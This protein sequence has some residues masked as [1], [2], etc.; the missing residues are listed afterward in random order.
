M[1]CVI[2]RNEIYY[3][4]KMTYKKYLF[5]IGAVAIIGWVSFVL[6][7]LKLDPCTSPG[8]LSLCYS[9]SPLALFLFFVSAFF[10]F[11]STFTLLGFGLRLWL[12]QYEIYLDHLG[13]SLRQGILLTFCTLCAIAFLLLNALTWWSGLLLIGIIILLEMYF[14]R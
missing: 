4:E 8:K 1:L 2:V 10:A 11:T 6:V 7:I 3:H 14:S 9:T 5:I 13:I 12:N